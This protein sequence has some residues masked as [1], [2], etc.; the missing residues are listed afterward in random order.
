MRASS[1]CVYESGK[2][3]AAIKSGW[4]CQPNAAYRFVIEVDLYALLDCNAT[5][6]H[7]VLHKPKLAWR[8]IQQVCFTAITTMSWLPALAV[9]DQLLLV[10][11]LSTLPELPGYVFS[12]VADFPAL[13]AEPRFL[14]VTGAVCRVSM[15]EKYTQSA[16]F[17]C[18]TRDCMRNSCRCI[19]LHIAGASEADI[20]SALVEDVSC[21][22]LGDKLT[23]S[24]IPVKALQMA[25][26]TSWRHQAI[27]VILRDE[28]CE[29]I[30]M[31]LEYTVVGI[32]MYELSEG[33]SQAQISITVEANNIF[34]VV[35]KIQ[36][37]ISELPPHMME[38]Y[39]ACKYSPW[40]FTA[41]LAYSFGALMPLAPAGTYHR[42]KLAMLLSLVNMCN[43]DGPN[44]GR[45]SA[46]DILAVG[47]DVSALRQLMI[48]GGSFA[49]RCILHCMTGD[50]CGTTKKDGTSIFVDGGNLALAKG[51][52]CMVGNLACLKKD[53][54]DKLQQ[55]IETGQITLS[56]SSSEGTQNI[57]WPLGCSMWTC[58]STHCQKPKGS[59][60]VHH[61]D[62]P[63]IRPLEEVLCIS[64]AL[65]QSVALFIATDPSTLESEDYLAELL[66]VHI[67][68]A[69]TGCE[70]EVAFTDCDF[71]TL[72]LV[73]SQV[74]PVVSD[75]AR[76]L[77]KAFYLASRTVRVSAVYGTDV[78]K[79][80]LDTMMLV[81]MAH[82][83]LSLRNEVTVEDA[84]MAI[85]LYEE[86]LVSRLGYSVLSHIPTPHFRGRDIG[87]YIGKEVYL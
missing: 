42:L 13:N 21:R 3:A 45:H 38:M 71:K 24:L 53:Q 14:L 12:C 28:L 51:G 84:T 16:C 76:N 41:T 15:L 64:R 1:A 33:T 74:H 83:K 81:A 6:G 58:Q 31:G 70:T 82:S 77:I 47:Q 44:I 67:L 63:L 62:I 11:R 79:S 85:L 52:V 7:L 20:T 57:S 73:A 55:S 22:V 8:L 87:A 17:C 36:K 18:P 30:Q 66:A 19:R 86:S 25:F 2:Y 59:A 61:S 72:L 29:G 23:V 9:S 80:A 54:I 65:I 75:E 32:P 78:V 37:S 43:A 48:Y 27:I 60:K 4:R 39:H 10:L 40:A 50:L 26:N 68:S 49:P 56:T 35:L 69:A 5:L 34:P 46:L